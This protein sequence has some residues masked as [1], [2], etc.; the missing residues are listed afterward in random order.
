MQALQHPPVLLYAGNQ[1]CL[2][3]EK[4]AY[5]QYS[6][7]TM[8]LTCWPEDAHQQACCLSVTLPYASVHAIPE[9]WV[10]LK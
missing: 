4:L 2:N 3:A 1:H 8:V 5:E 10:G 6:I 7:F 9:L